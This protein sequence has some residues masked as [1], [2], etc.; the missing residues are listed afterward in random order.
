MSFKI[1][2]LQAFNRDLHLALAVLQWSKVVEIW[3]AQN[4][5]GNNPELKVCTGTALA[6]G[7][8]QLLT[9][10]CSPPNGGMLLMECEGAAPDG[11]RGR[12]S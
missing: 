12:R 8:L 10:I 1:D 6:D 11:V 7:Q 9:G 5:T 4:E 2:L 3:G